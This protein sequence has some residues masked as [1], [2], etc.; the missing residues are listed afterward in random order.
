[1]G[2]SFA[3][4][5]AIAL[6]ALCLP[7]A[8]RAMSLREAVNA[9]LLIH[10]Q[11]HAALA[12]AERAGT[13]V[14][15]A[16]T[17]YF[18]TLQLSGGPKAGDMGALVYDVTLSQPLF[19]W[20]RAGSAVAKAGAEQR[21]LQ[22]A[23]E[24]ARDDAA[25]DITETYLDVLLAGRRAGAAARYV[26]RTEAVARMAQLRSGSGYADRAESERANL[27]LARGREQLAVEEGAL[28]DAQGQFRILVGSDAVGLLEPV[29]VQ[30]PGIGDEPGLQQL[31]SHSPLQRRA[32]E[33]INKA[34]A[35]MRRARAALLP[36]LNVEAS[37][38]R[39]EIGGH[40]QDD[41]VVAVRLRMDPMQGLSGF[42]RSAAARQQ[43]EAAY[44]N[45]DATRRELRRKLHSLQDSAATLE[46]RLAALQIQVAE[47]EQVANLYRDQFGIGRRDIVDLLTVQ[48]EQLEAE[49]QLLALQSERIR[50]GYRAAAQL[51]L[52]CSLL[53]GNGHAH[54]TH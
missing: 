22:A 12:E 20:G 44:W 4:S 11:W 23:A 46:R 15:I 25:L 17:G 36:Q 16:R 32:E 1:M 43:M 48:R 30:I 34:E 29:A 6:L 40:M 24:V 10:P 2:A 49:R 5:V 38:L 9:G 35:D 13:E 37:A 45:A 3:S 53:E 52:L 47:A 41:A 19:D 26:E 51:G 21:G 18:P 54:A 27:E 39:R 28:A 8:A 42:Q 33:V 31:I 14:D 7:P 50:L